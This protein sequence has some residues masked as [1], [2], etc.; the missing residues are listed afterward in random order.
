MYYEVYIDTL[1]LINFIMDFLI[2][3]FVGKILKLNTTWL[4]LTGASALGSL[5]ICLSVI[6]PIASITLNILIYYVITCV[7]M[8]VIGFKPKSII[9]LIKI[10]I[11][12]YLLTFLIG[13]SII[14]LY[15]Y[16]K[17]GYYFNQLLSGNVFSAIDTRTFILTSIIAFILIK[18]ILYYFSRVMTVQKNLFSIEIELQGKSIRAQGLL[19]T[20]NN[21]YDPI[22]KA[23]VIIVEYDIIKELIPDQA[24]DIIIKFLNNNSE[25]FYNNIEE[26]YNH[27]FR[28]IPFSSIGKESGMLIGLVSENV[29]INCNTEKEF[30]LKDIVLA[31]YNK[32]LS[33]DNSYQILIHPEMVK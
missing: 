11:G 3:W 10:L 26:L 33:Q 29:S 21:L 6:F 9:Q 28:L 2:L 27:K 30:K 5:I 18:M 22:T 7:L 14:S 13:G 16:T 4:R 24:R 12:L 1:F 32:K 25:D 15:Y 31:I 23:P 19:D 20:G 8:I 17:A